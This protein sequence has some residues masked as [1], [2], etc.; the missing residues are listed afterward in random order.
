MVEQ[1]LLPVTD[2]RLDPNNPRLPSYVDTSD[3]EQIFE[4]LAKSSA[5]DELVSAIGTNDYFASEPL[6]G[7][8][9]DDEVVIVEGNRR[10]T[11]LKILGGDVFEGMP[12]KLQSIVDDAAFHPESVPVDLYPARVDVLTYLGNKH[13]A[14]VKPWGA[15]AKARY[16]KQLFENFGGVGGYQDRVK[17]VARSIG[18]RSDFI[19]RSLKALEA[20]EVAEEQ[21]FFGLD[22]VDETSV[23]FSLLSTALDY[24]GVQ[25]FV[26]EDADVPFDER[27]LIQENLRKLFDWMFAKGANGKT[28]LGESR[29]LSKLSQ[30]VAS[31]PALTAFERGFTLE[32]A[33]K[34]TDGIDR[35]FDRL[36][37]AVLSGLREAN[38]IV[39]DVQVTQ[40]RIVDADSIRKQ[41]RQLNNHFKD[42]D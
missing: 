39:A 41:A 29:N 4:F 23:K 42:D 11:A 25:D 19:A 14:G 7:V 16:V 10:L 6:I 33:Y 40:D 22:G 9:E 1:K 3:E 26:Y 2:L 5:I 12:K 13:I 38:S 35:E 8:V 28:R 21:E 15:L 34:T 32:Q 17:R 36:T 37:A 24:E 20:Y 30:V 31:Q 18:S 27:T